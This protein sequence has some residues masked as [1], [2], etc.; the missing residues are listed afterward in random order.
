MITQRQLIHEWRKRNYTQRVWQFHEIVASL[1]A[2]AQEL[3]NR[4]S[5]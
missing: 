4:E 3:E 1:L 5:S 2:L